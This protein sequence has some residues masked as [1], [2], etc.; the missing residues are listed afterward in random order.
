MWEGEARNVLADEL[1]LAAEQAAERELF[2]GGDLATLEACAAYAVAPLTTP[3]GRPLAD[4]AAGRLW[5]AAVEM[6]GIGAA[7][8]LLRAMDSSAFDTEVAAARRQADNLARAARKDGNPF[9]AT[10]Q[11]VGILCAA[12][13]LGSERACTRLGRQNSDRLPGRR[14]LRSSKRAARSTEVRN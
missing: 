7:V 14:G 6:G 8:R 2:A 5:C 1:T 11:P 12:G 9:G 3:G 4:G 10:L 13:G